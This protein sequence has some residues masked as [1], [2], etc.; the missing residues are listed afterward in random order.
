MWK[1]VRFIDA[2]MP[3]LRLTA[4][5]I[6]INWRCWQTARTRAVFCVCKPACDD[7]YH[8]V[9]PACWRRVHEPQQREQV[10]GCNTFCAVCLLQGSGLCA[11]ELLHVLQVRAKYGGDLETHQAEQLS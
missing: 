9:L 5:T 10:H 11:A 3:L 7:C 8:A 2:V 6:N 1:F 4:T